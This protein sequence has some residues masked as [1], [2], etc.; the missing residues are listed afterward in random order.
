MAHYKLIIGIGQSQI[1]GREEDEDAPVGLLVG[2][3]AEGVKQFDQTA[4]QDW[5]NLH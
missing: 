1:D 2:A 3:I 4:I 5:D